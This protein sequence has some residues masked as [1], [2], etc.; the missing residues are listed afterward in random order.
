[1]RVIVIGAGIV[2]AS[3]AYHLSRQG[4]EVTLVD[5]GADGQA[6]AAGAGIVC[7]WL[8]R[9]EDPDWYRLAVAGA[10]YYPEL[11]AL[12]AADGI[13]DT[14]YRT[15]GAMSLADTDADLAQIADRA[16]ARR[17]SA[18]EVGEITVLAAGEPAGLFPPLAA[19][20][21][22]VHVSGAARVDG[23]QVRDAL[24]AAGHAH[25]VRRLTGSATV[26]VAGNG[27]W[28]A[29]IDGEPAAGDAVVVAA[30]AWTPEIVP[31][32]PVEPQ[33]GQI[34]HLRLPGAET[35]RWPV[36]LPPSSHYLLAF[37]GSRVVVG[38]TRETGSGFDH[39]VTAAGL[40]EVLDQ[41]ISVAP[42]LADATVV[43][44]RIGFRPFSATPLIGPIA[45]GSPVIVATG[46]GATGLTMGPLVGRIAAELAL[47][48]PASLDIAAFTPIR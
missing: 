10:G 16:R 28:Q 31:D 32:V 35:D 25:G 18:P 3:T 8:S 42:G 11:I 37:E 27:S 7:P 40:R 4:A 43:E 44:T 19:H 17:I 21:S 12:L 36:V 41:A 26:A 34:V 1:M 9:T 39:R 48:H 33:R 22:A 13:A 38:A 30:G 29:A 23:R 24:L 47:R 45:T 14:G 5:R 6:T 15:V 20:W 46:L 2:G